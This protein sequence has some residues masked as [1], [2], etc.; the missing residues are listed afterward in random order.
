MAHRLARA[1][2]AAASAALAA[3]ASAPALVDVFVG[4]DDFNATSV[5]QF[6]I[7][8]LVR[9]GKGTLLAFAEARTA[10][11]T[12]CGYKWLVVRRSE[13]EGATWSKSTDVA[14]RE[15]GRWA[16]GN[17]QAVFHAPSG[18][19]I[20]A[21]GSKDLSKHGGC[22]PST[23]VFVVDDGGTDGVAWG[24][25]RNISGELGVQW[26]TILPGPGAGAVL[27]TAPH[28]G[29]IV[30]S[31]VTDA[32]GKVITMLSDDAGASWRA[33]RSPLA[34]G[35]ESAATELPDGRVYLSMRNA[36]LNAS[37]DCQAYA[38]SDDGGETFG[39]M[40]FDATL[41]S[42]VC[43]ASVAVL[44]TRLLFA[45]P[46]SR[47]ERRDITVRATAAGA[48]DPTAWEWSLLLAPGVTFGGYTSLASG[49]AGFGA[50][51]LERNASGADVISFARFALPAAP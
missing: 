44:E 37:C 10:P 42:P 21:F 1:L 45:N 5:K 38:L 20:L 51:L 46:A 41:V 31:G 24:P 16:T 13:D 23:A 19:V 27:Q 25:P 15:W 40:Q 48:A 49:G 30:L 26:A 22:E 8:A 34:G 17:P 2:F 50:A 14:G 39:P 32:Y 6:R 43:E 3:S 7:P 35:D 11:Q 18:R 33:G 47:S 29:R 28:A 4:G 9:T 36:D 12:D